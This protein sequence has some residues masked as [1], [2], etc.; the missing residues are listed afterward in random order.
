[1]V[2]HLGSKYA[3]LFCH[4]AFG[5]IL[6]LFLY[7]DFF[8]IATGATLGILSMAF[9]FVQAVSSIA[10]MTEILYL[11]P[12]ENKSFSTGLWLT[13]YQGGIGLSGL[14]SSKVL[15]L[16]ILTDSWVFMGNQM[17]HYDSLLLILGAM[18]MLMVVTLGLVPS[19]LGTSQSHQGT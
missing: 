7:R 3:F 4:L 15:D 16:K 18:V 13:L 8:P 1:M 14:I 17:T 2:D 9:G 6:F 11:I 12:V 5:L 19:V 10:M